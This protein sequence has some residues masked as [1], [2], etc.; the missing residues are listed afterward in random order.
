M[1][2][3]IILGLIFRN[4]LR[5][6]A[7]IQKLDD[8][9]L[10]RM[11]Y[12]GDYGFDDFLEVGATNDNELAGIVAKRLLHG[13][14]INLNLDFGFPEDGGCTVFVVK[15]EKGEVLYCRN[16]DFSYT[17]AMQVFTSPDNGYRSVS[18]IQS[19]VLGYTK[20]SYPTGININSFFAL[21]APYMPWDGMN[22]KGV[23]IGLLAVPEAYGPH[24]NEITLSTTT[25]IRLVL[26]KASTVNEAVDL[27]RQYN[28]YFSAGINC[29]F[30][31]ADRS[32]DSVLVEYWDGELVTVTTPED[33]QVASNF[34]A[35]NGLNIGEGFTEFERHE[36]A[37]SAIIENGGYLT[38]QQAI[39]LLMEVGIYD[40]DTDKLQ[41][42]VV[43]NLTTGTGKILA[44]RNTSNIHSFD[45]PSNGS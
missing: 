18:T 35:Y 10:S 13:I 43:Y 26:D 7:S 9:P 29:H 16:Y 31:L 14:P 1:V 34:V 4:E 11:T 17:P 2:V 23:A 15:N 3:I 38:E 36:T 27:M 45:I 33:Y 44:N 5:S 21:A 6:L 20:N 28:V 30:L 42:T 19:D 41:W 8:H 39:D 40:G 25:I 24:S 22:E 32:G 12:Y 37:K